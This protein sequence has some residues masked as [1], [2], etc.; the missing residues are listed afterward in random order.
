[1]YVYVYLVEKHLYMCQQPCI[2]EFIVLLLAIMRKWEMIY[3]G[4]LYYN[5]IKINWIFIHQKDKLWNITVV[6][7][8]SCK[9]V[10]EVFSIYPRSV[11]LTKHY[12]QNIFIYWRYIHPPH[13]HTHNYTQWLQKMHNF[14]IMLPLEMF[15]I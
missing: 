3:S 12:T 5:E 13:T 6:G 14:R 1:M 15:R 4:I 10:H 9:I 8:K 11:K 7:K 2:K